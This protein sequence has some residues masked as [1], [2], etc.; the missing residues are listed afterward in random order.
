MLYTSSR[1]VIWL[2]AWKMPA[3]KGL[4]WPLLSL[5][6]SHPS[7]NPFCP[8]PQWAVPTSRAM[9]PCPGRSDVRPA[10][11]TAPHPSLGSGISVPAAGCTCPHTAEF[12]RTGW[13]QT[14]R[15]L[16]LPMQMPPKEHRDSV[17]TGRNQEKVFCDL[18]QSNI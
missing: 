4:T 11:P 2:A 13:V 16:L 1:A 10:L 7:P 6:S 18:Q 17:T 8:G 12:G 5:L 15:I 3:C 14:Q 9:L